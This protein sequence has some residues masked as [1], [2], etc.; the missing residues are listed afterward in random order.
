MSRYC[1]LAL[2]SSMCIGEI[3]RTKRVDSDCGGGERYRGHLQ[4]GQGGSILWKPPC[5]AKRRYLLT[6]QVSRYHLLALQSRADDLFMTTVMRKHTNNHP[7]TLPTTKETLCRIHFRGS[8]EG[9][10]VHTGRSCRHPL[11]ARSS[12]GSLSFSR[13]KWWEIELFY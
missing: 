2:C 8:T 11:I 7:S 13:F 1:L 5:K 9:C 4:S 3:R 6:L 10:T 12:Q